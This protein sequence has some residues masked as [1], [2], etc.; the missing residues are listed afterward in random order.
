MRLFIAV[1]FPDRVLDQLH[2]IAQDLRGGCEC[3]NFVPR[4]NFHLTLAFLGEIQDTQTEDIK[5]AM[6]RVK[7][8]V[9]SMTISGL[10]EFNR[11]GGYIYWLGIN[12]CPELN[13]LQS[14]LADEVRN[15]G[16]V[17]EKR[18]FHP[19]LTLGRRV[20]VR[21]DFCL[22]QFK[23]SLVDIDVPVEAISLMRSDRGER[24]VKY[25][26]IHAVKL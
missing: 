1:N 26:Q 7:S 17:L 19:H 4:E 16:F 18:A 23:N 10:G 8:T 6:E 12:K 9:F 5:V 13:I 2:K 20:I 15:R 24:G 25:R 14:S 22:E 3:G 11:Q 21:K